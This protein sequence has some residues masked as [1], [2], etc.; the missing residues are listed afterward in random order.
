M[1]LVLPPE[2]PAA[3]RLVRAARRARRA[4]ASDEQWQ[5]YDEQLGLG[6]A[7]WLDTRLDAQFGRGVPQR[8]AVYRALPTEPPTDGICAA[9][10]DRGVRL[11]VPTM[12]PDKDLSWLDLITGEDLG[13]EAIHDAGLIVV[14]ALAVARTTGLRLGQ[15]G[16]SYDRAL[17]RKRSGS[18][19][20]AMLFD[21]E[22]VDAVPAESH[23][24]PVDF[25]L[26]PSGAASAVGEGI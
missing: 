24:R 20:I 2:K 15:G 25:V 18:A 12:L 3:R 11:I 22:V 19:V 16:G 8:A 13:V 1:P 26:T 4:D 17:A 21:E 9:L 14:P 7:R 6:L 10:V 5:A 23:D